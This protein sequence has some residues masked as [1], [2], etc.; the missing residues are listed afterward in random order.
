M[1]QPIILAAGKGTRM[2]SELPKALF[3]FSG[4]AMLDWVLEAMARVEEA[5]TPIVVVG[6]K[7]ESVRE[8]VGERAICVEQKEIT[9]TATAVANAL[10]Y[11]PDDVRN[12]FIMYVDQPFIT[13][14]SIKAIS[15]THEET[16]A[17]L[18]LG[19]VKLPDYSDWR[20]VF[21][22]FGR[23]IRDPNGNVAEIVEYKNANEIERATLEVN[24]G[25]YCVEVA[26]LK[27]ALSRINA[28]E[29]T[30]E[31]Y[32]TDILALAIDDEKKISSVFITP[33]EGLG[34]NSVKDAE[35]AEALA[36]Q[37]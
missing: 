23:I 16:G 19:T 24:P 4:K 28:N 17:T 12:V 21:V 37:G 5:L 8:Y 33:E 18:T 9:G 27:N 3:P 35:F 22:A 31:Y 20:S 6:H 34:I 29:M 15:K 1:L 11:V 2:Q 32:L 7:G 13:P 10:P 14:E 30:G 36:A 25:F 26:W